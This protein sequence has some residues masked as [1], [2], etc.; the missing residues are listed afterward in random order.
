MRLLKAKHTFGAEVLPF[1]ISTLS[2]IDDDTNWNEKNAMAAMLEKRI[3]DEG[4]LH[5]LLIT[6]KSFHIWKKHQHEI[7]TDY[8]IWYGNNR[9]RYAKK[10]NYTHIDCVV[11]DHIIKDALCEQMQIPTKTNNISQNIWL[12]DGKRIEQNKNKG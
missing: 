8:V 4:M 10:H 7:S 11:V 12:E 1:S 9:F 6:E 3:P 2:N 5:P